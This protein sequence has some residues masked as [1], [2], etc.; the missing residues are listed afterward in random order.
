MKP[1]ADYRESLLKRLKNPVEAAAYINAA[2]ETG[3]S[4]DFLTAI[5][6]VVESRGNTAQIARQSHL[7]RPHI[8]KILGKGGNPEFNT[9]EKLLP[10][11]GLRLSVSPLSPDKAA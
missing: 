7:T 9:M 3:D 11:L 10:A 8:Y 5:R 4:Q 1:Y 2:I 6:N